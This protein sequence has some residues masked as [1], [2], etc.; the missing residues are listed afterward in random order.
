MFANNTKNQLQAFNLEV[1]M[2]AQMWNAFLLVII[3]FLDL[4]SSYIDTFKLYK[5]EFI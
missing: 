3:M 1:E 5:K 2:F 4:K